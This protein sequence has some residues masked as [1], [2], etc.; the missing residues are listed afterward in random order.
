[1]RLPKRLRAPLTLALLAGSLAG[2]Q[3][4]LPHQPPPE[5]APALT[6]PA[7][8]LAP[9]AYGISQL[10][11]R[12]GE[13]PLN[14]TQAQRQELER[15][16]REAQGGDRSGQLQQMLLAQTIDPAALRAQLVQSAAEI[17]QA[18]ATQVR[19]RNVLTAEQRQTLI[20]AFRQ[21]GGQASSTTDEQMQ[22]MQRQLN[23][24]AE[25][26]Q[27]MTAMNTALQRHEEANRS[28]L[29]QATIALIQ[30]GDGSAYRQALV[31]INRTMPVDAMVA[32]FSSLS[33]TQ[34]QT[35]FGNTGGGGSGSG[36]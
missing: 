22:A 13:D 36:R 28:R 32:F 7:G 9:A 24:T 34:R 17:D 10:N 8:W 19:M 30:T 6:V 11:Q 18:V 31:E 20:Q 33:Q 26:Q 1:M 14:L 12:Q 21:E 29:S 2:C 23:L 5:P 15:I 4:S 35:L 3:A 16:G 27:A 25:Q